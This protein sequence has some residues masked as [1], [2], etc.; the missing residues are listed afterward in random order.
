MSTLP[1][2]TDDRIVWDTWLAMFR[3]PVVSVADEV[4]TFAAIS[5]R[6]KE[7]GE[8]AAEL[9]VDE[10]ALGVHLGMLAALGYV[11]RRGG[12]WRATAA[13]RTWL[14]PQADGY[15]G[16]LVKRFAEQQPLHEQLM[17]TL[18][19]GGRAETY[20]S[21]SAE[22]ERGEMPP[23]LAAGITAFMNAHSRASSRA[24]A[25]LPVFDGVRHVLDVG[26]GSGIFSIE[27]VR[28]WPQLRATV[29]DIG[30]ICSE[31]ARYIAAAG[32]GGRVATHAANMF[33]E[34]WARGHDVHFFSNVFHDWSGETC[35]LLAK[36]SFEALPPGGRILL[37]EMLMD[38][39]GCGPLHAAAFSLLMLMG[40]RGRQYS[41]PELRGFLEQ[42]GFTD[43]EAQGTGQGYYSL[44]SA[45]RP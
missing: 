9:G 28:A 8:L 29:L 19:T 45:R 24:V 41:L 31:A 7:T 36:R 4:G 23:D 10:R 13:A 18:R 20:R 39:D 2:T 16:P 40:T 14:H 21:A 33:T 15:A 27:L 26:G 5:A 42:A 34:P 43:V 3:F 12:R 1:V 22:W 35:C 6:A 32:V 30:T 44:V 25:M 38:D 17:V 37:H 11:E